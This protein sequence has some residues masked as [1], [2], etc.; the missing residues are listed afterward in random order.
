MSFSPRFHPLTGCVLAF[1]VLL[2]SFVSCVWRS[3]SPSAADVNSDGTWRVATISCNVYSRGEQACRGR[4]P[5][6]PL[7]PKNA[8]R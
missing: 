4:F 2:P 3:F 5:D 1:H 8:T 7:S 6:M